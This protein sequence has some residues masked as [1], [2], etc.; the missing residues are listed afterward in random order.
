MQEFKLPQTRSAYLALYFMPEPVPD[1][2]PAEIEQSLP[3][4]YRLPDQ[5]A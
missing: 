1:E 2:I 5:D 3:A 4:K